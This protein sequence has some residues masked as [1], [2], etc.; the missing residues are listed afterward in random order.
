[1]R[2]GM[3]PASTRVDAK[4]AAP[5]GERVAAGPAQVDRAGRL[6]RPAPTARRR[7]RTQ[8]AAIAAQLA[9]RHRPA[10]RGPRAGSSSHQALDQ[11]RRRAPRRARAQPGRSA[12]AAARAATARARPRGRRP[13]AVGDRGQ[14]ERGDLGDDARRPRWAQP[15]RRRPAR[16]R[17]REGACQRR[18]D[19]QAQAVAREAR[20]VVAVVVD[21]SAG[22]AGARRPRSPRA[23]ARSHG[24]RPG[25]AVALGRPA[26]SP[27]SA[28]DAAAAQRLQQEGLGLV[29][30]VVGRAARG[31]RRARSAIS[32]KRAVARRARP[33]LDA[34]ARAAGRVGEAASRPARPAGRAAPSVRRAARVGEPGVGVGA[35]AVVHVQREHRDARA[36]RPA[37]RVAC[38]S[39]VESRPPLKATATT[40]RCRRCVSARWCR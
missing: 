2:R 24:P 27:T 22:D 35:Q 11:A 5:A 40:R 19:P 10:A 6:A 39:A 4:R 16:S 28:G 14:V 32:R 18:P 31:R 7:L 33:G 1:M 36:A 12:L 30:P 23:A 13:L 15:R 29:A 26:A 17:R 25:D 21:R 34:L 9:A 37:R 20:V 3:P 38:S 8:P